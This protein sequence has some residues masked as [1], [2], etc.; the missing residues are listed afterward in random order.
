MNSKT[1][2]SVVGTWWKVPIAPSPLLSRK[3]SPGS[4]STCINHLQSSFSVR[5][6]FCLPPHPQSHFTKGNTAFT[7]VEMLIAIAIMA[8]LAALL[9]PVFRQTRESAKSAKSLSN[10][11]TIGIAILGYTA[12]NDGKFPTMWSS[13]SAAWTPPFWTDFIKPYLGNRTYDLSKTADLN[14]RPEVYKCPAWKENEHQYVSDYGNNCFVIVPTYSDPSNTWWPNDPVQLNRIP[15]PSQTVMV[16]NSSSGTSTGPRGTWL[17]RTDSFIAN[18]QKGAAC[19]PGPIFND[20]VHSVFADGHTE[21][22]PYEEFVERRREL[23]GVAPFN[24]N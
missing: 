2:R 3:D 6:P 20:V 7:L 10:L 18:P 12:D 13:D 4:T 17:I 19:Q 21:A 1:L 9:I 14:Y 23:M 11:R 8:V 16:A 24:K 15:T 22:I 5:S